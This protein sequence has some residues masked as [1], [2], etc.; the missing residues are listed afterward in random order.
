MAGNTVEQL[1]V[2]LD[3]RT[4]AFEQRLATA[5][6]KL[7]GFKRSAGETGQVVGSIGNRAQ[8][9]ALAVANAAESMARSGKVAG[10]G[11]RTIVNQGAQAAFFFG[12]QGALVGA[13]AVAGLAIVE[14]FQRTKKETQDI[15]DQLDAAVAQREGRVRRKQQETID[16]ERQRLLAEIATLQNVTPNAKTGIDDTAAQRATEIKKLQEELKKLGTLQGELSRQITDE[17]EQALGRL[18]QSGK[19]TADQLK[20]A[21]AQAARLRKELEG[22]PDTPAGRV[23]RVG[24]QSRIDALTPKGPSIAASVNKDLQEA[25]RAAEE[26]LRKRAAIQKEIAELVVQATGDMADDIALELDRFEQRLREAGINESEIASLVALKKAALAAKK[27]IE[28]VLKAKEKLDVG[29]GPRERTGGPEDTDAARRDRERVEAERQRRIEAARYADEVARAAFAAADLAANFG[30]AGREVAA[31][32]GQLGGIASTIGDI[33]ANGFSL[34]NVAQLAGQIGSMLFAEDPDER[35]NRETNRELIRSLNRLR[36]RVGDLIGV[37]TPGTTIGAVRRAT[38][39][40]RTSDAD[41]L[42]GPIKV[43]QRWQQALK[44][45]GVSMEEATEFAKSLG[46][47]LTRFTV[48]GFRAFQAALREFD[49]SLFF[50]TFAGQMEQLEAEFEINGITDPIDQ[51]IRKA[52][53]LSKV[54]PAFA[55]LF[56]GLDLATLEGR[57]EA[58]RRLREQWNRFIENPKEFGE[59]L[60]ASGLSLDEWKQQ[61]LD[62][63]RV[64]TDAAIAAEKFSSVLDGLFLD[65]EIQGVTDPRSRADATVAAAATADKRFQPLIGLDLGSAEGRAAAEQILQ[66]LALGADEEFKRLILDVLRAIRAIPEAVAEERPGE[67]EV[68]GNAARGLTEVTGNRMADFL[69]TGLILDRERNTLLQRLVDLFRGR[70]DDPGAAAPALLV[71]PSPGPLVAPQI[72]ATSRTAGTSISV[73]IGDTTVNVPTGVVTNQAQLEDFL[74]RRMLVRISEGLAELGK[75]SDKTLGIVRATG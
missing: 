31:F 67:V 44:A 30:D 62:V 54:S 22:I 32:L 68:V 15:L 38:A 39:T 75:E 59:A 63:S 61:M 25:E 21:A 51:L 41:G 43:V 20:D 52:Q 24:I 74:T 46:F 29:T 56:E 34:A 37:T 14:I 17:Q 5:E 12:P 60:E 33:A 57:A 11:L 50:D 3:A 8:N 2:E 28:D 48:E 70:G 10:E 26:F 65:Q 47:D 18:V 42:F 69:R 16:A 27:G 55:K 72:P 73:S 7:G 19:A 49:F 9:A 66:G 58:A 64:L 4:A 40:V 35:L 71:P 53:V 6:G 13:I 1:V 36:E 23:Q 45:A